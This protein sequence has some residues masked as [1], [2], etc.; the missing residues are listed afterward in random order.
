MEEM[1]GATNACVATLRRQ[2]IEETMDI[3]EM[4]FMTTL[5]IAALLWGWL[6][7]IFWLTS[8]VL[9]LRR[10]GVCRSKDGRLDKR[11]CPAIF[12]L[13]QTSKTQNRPVTSQ[14]SKPKHPS[15]AK[16]ANHDD[17][18]RHARHRRGSCRQGRSDQ[19]ASDRSV[20]LCTWYGI[21]VGMALESTPAILPGDCL[22]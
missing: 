6:I 1:L 9:L 13:A 15:K 4:G 5:L 21:G 11:K 22:L 12:F 14:I 8:D 7:D 19:G 3:N 2:S 16:Q 20:M 17:R 10:G 18:R